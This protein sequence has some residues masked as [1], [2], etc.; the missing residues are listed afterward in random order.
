MYAV[1]V[2][3]GTVGLYC[4]TL[5]L[6][7]T[8]YCCIFNGIM[9]KGFLYKDAFPLLLYVDAATSVLWYKALRFAGGLRRP[10][11]SLRREKH[12]KLLSKADRGT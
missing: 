11:R 6:Y 8:R 2:V 1:A 7:Y 10:L 3:C 9:L 12:T 4:C 5:L